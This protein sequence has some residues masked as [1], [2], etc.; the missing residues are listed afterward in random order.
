MIIWFFFE[1]W[2]M[3]RDKYL[4]VILYYNLDIDDHKILKKIS[5][6]IDKLLINGCF[7]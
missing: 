6:D 7:Y 2:R 1:M 4:K 5:S 3:S